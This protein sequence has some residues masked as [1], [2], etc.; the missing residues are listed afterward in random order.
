MI[1]FVNLLNLSS[2]RLGKF[3]R[4]FRWIHRGCYCKMAGKTRIFRF[5]AKIRVNKSNISF[6][7]KL[8]NWESNR[9]KLSNYYSLIRNSSL[10]KNSTES[11]S[12][13]GNSGK[14]NCN[15]NNFDYSNNIRKSIGG[16]MYRCNGSNQPRRLNS[17]T[18]SFSRWKP[19]RRCKRS[20]SSNCTAGKT[21]NYILGTYF[22]LNNSRLFNC[23]SNTVLKC[24]SGN[25]TRR[26]LGNL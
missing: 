21:K 1:K 14:L 23:S 15:W 18:S 24:N 10:R 20:S 8:N 22:G 13:I 16:K 5:T 6:D 7:S 3:A 2:N 11:R 17:F 9:C 26:K 25:F 4:T 12:S 19:F